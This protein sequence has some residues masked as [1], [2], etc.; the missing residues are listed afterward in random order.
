MIKR[1]KILSIA[2]LILVLFSILIRIDYAISK[3]YL[4]ND[5]GRDLSNTLMMIKRG[6]PLLIGPATSFF[7]SLGNLPFG[8]YYY[9]L[10]ALPLFISRHPFAAESIFILSYA[11]ILFLILGWKKLSLESKLIFILLFGF[12]LNSIYHTT[13]IWNLNLAGLA[14]F[15]L[16]AFAKR[17]Q[18]I[19]ERPFFT[20]IYGL[21]LGAVFQI[22]YGVFFVVAIIFLQSFLRKR[23]STLYL[24]LGFALSFSPLIIFDLRH[25]FLISRI[26]I[27]LPQEAGRNNLQINI[28]SSI[29]ELGKFAFPIFTDS[30]L[31][32]IIL[33]IIIS[34]LILFKNES[35][36]NKLIFILFLA[37]FILLR[38]KFTYYAALYLPFLYLALA[39]SKTRLLKN[40]LILFSFVVALISV[41]RYT[42]E[43]NL[44]LGIKTQLQMAKK[45]AKINPDKTFNLS[46]IPHD[47]DKKGVLY[48]LES[49]YG[50]SFRSDDPDAY[51]ICYDKTKCLQN[52]KEIIY[53]N[54]EVMLIRD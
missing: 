32:H 14:A 16:Y 46:A 11:I 25:Q 49:L 23:V 40:I 12:A 54:P 50:L 26:L 53:E 37:T 33:F 31:F 28:L 3:A 51:T 17:Y 7:T 2:L 42:S 19:F 43:E 21:L 45:I 52:F 18:G 10:L 15:I 44:K 8:P 24:S 5:Q 34:T 48:L 6:R 1:K 41:L 13:F 35:R 27:N 47:D 20:A 38:R 36:E 9:Y 30:N 39:Q 29:L 4:V 22:H